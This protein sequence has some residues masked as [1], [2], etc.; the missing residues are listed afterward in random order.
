MSYTN[1]DPDIIVPFKGKHVVETTQQAWLVEQAQKEGLSL[2]NA[3]C[4]CGCCPGSCVDCQEADAC[5]PKINIA[6][7]EDATWSTV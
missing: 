3:A 7:G 1:Q 5:A 2:S 6:S 4:W